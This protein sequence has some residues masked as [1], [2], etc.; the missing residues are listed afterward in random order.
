MMVVELIEKRPKEV[1]KRAEL[2]H[3][4]G[5][6]VESGRIDH[7]RKSAVCFVTLAERK[8]RT[9][10][11]IKV[12]NR[13]AAVVTPSIINALKDFPDDLVK[14]ITFDRRKEFSGYK[15]AESK[16]NYNTYFCDPHCAWQKGTNRNTNGLL[17]EF[18]P[19]GMDF[20][21]IDEELK[22]YLELMNNRPRKCL[23]YKTPNEI[24]YEI[25]AH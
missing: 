9:Y 20:S 7:K 10:I 4:E 14:T 25:N 6:I 21:Q 8:S 5:D 11:A 2:G 15:K 19:K 1:Y 3:W 24:I 23:G 22:Y 16:R 17:R 12:P 18:Y 13:T